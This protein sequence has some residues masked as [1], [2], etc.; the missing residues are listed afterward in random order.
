ML[1][2]RQV[3]SVN[4]SIYAL[5]A[6]HHYAVQKGT[7][8]SPHPGKI[9]H[10]DFLLTLNL[11]QYA[12]AKAIH[13]PPRRINEIVKGTRALTADTALRLAAYFNVSEY[14]WMDL[15]NQHELDIQR[16]HRA[17]ELLKIKPYGNDGV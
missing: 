14:Y 11:S 7:N 16:Q 12:L 6:V 5:H 17:K 13:V 9:L 4:A 15:Q 10:S 1:V 3:N 8:M 2:F